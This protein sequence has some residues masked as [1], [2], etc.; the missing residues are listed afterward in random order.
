MKA[1]IRPFWLLITTQASRGFSLRCWLLF[2]PLILSCTIISA[3]SIGNWNFNNVLTGTPGSHNTVSTADFSVAVPTRAFNGGTE[4]YGENGWPAG[5]VNTSVYLQFSLTPVAGYQMDINSIVLT[6]RRSNTGSP[7]G[8]GPTSWCIRSSLDGYTA[9]I[10]SGT[11]T[12]TYAAYT[13]TPGSAFLNL[14]SATTFRLYG[15]NASTG[16]GGMSR[17]VADNITV[18]GLGYLLASTLK[19]FAAIAREKSVALK[20]SLLNT[21]K[22]NQYLLE[23]S[24]DGSNFTAI[25]TTEETGNYA[26]KEYSYID[27]SLPAGFSKLFYRL[28]VHTQGGQDIY[29]AVSAVALQKTNTGQLLQVFTRQN[30]LYINGVFNSPGTY[31]AAIYTISGQLIAHTAVSIAGGYQAFVIPLQVNPSSACV[32]SLSN[33]VSCFNSVI[34]SRQ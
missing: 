9:N 17:L 18:N 24:T 25:H 11:M 12:L 34:V 3:Q 30:N 15:Y 33:G 1:T 4:Y 14:Y 21:E 29:S 16:A 28:H 26:E 10:A 8:S 19:S 32:V 13:V 5:A 22:L 6:I 7:A 23:R 2:T 31:Q 20:F 27:N